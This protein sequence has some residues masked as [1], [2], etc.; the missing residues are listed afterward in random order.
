MF[1]YLKVLLI[2][3]IINVCEVCQFTQYGFLIINVC[4][5]LSYPHDLASVMAMK[6]FILRKMVNIRHAINCYNNETMKLENASEFLVTIV[7]RDIPIYIPDTL[8][9]RNK[10][11]SRVRLSTLLIADSAK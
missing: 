6:L 4:E 9:L 5:L 10:Y 8:C 1:A 2:L 7:S 3:S 11:S